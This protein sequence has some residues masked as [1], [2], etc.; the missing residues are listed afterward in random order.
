MKDLGKISV[1]RH[2]VGEEA[3]GQRLDNYLLKL[4]KGVPKSHI[5]RIVRSGEVRVN[6]GRAGPDHRLQSGDELRLPPV[7]VAE[8]SVVRRVAPPNAQLERA[9][10]FE[11]DYLLALNK[12]AGLAVHGGSGVS[13]GAIEQLR[14]MR[15][16]A[17]FLELVHRL[18]RD[19]SGVLL[20][21]KKRSTLTGL[22]AEL[23]AGRVEKQYLVLVRGQWRDQKRHVRLNLHKYVLPSGERRVSVDPGGRESHTIFKLKQAW[24]QFSLLQAE[25]KTGR[26]HQIRVHLAHLGFPIA[27]D[28]KYGD[29]DFNKQLGR[30]K[31]KRMFLHASTI[32]FMHPASGETLKIEAPLPKELATFLAQLD[33]P[34]F[35]LSIEGITGRGERPS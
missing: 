14:A 3:D 35:G 29:F 12:P 23:R 33:R 6:R 8:R 4:L 32:E 11:D 25:L 18:D 27:G 28:D 22:H 30:S 5:Y 10:L 13:F 24:P 16:Q 15:P 2:Q 19:T 1:T 7:R 31:F 26:T 9:V 34:D 21:A 17:K 20:L